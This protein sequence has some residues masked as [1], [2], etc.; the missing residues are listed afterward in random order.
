MK[1]KYNNQKIKTEINGFD[2]LL[3]GGLQL[4][5]LIKEKENDN[6]N[7]VKV[8]SP[9]TIV[10]R[11]ELGTS[12]A[13]LAMQL[14]HGI[15]KSLRGLEQSEQDGAIEIDD[16]VFYTDDKQKINVEDML[17]DTVISKCVAKIVEARAKGVKGKWMR[18][19][20]CKT[21]F[22]L[23][24][25]LNIPINLQNLDA[26]VAQEII[27]YNSRSN[28]LHLALPSKAFSRSSS[29]DVLCIPRKYDRL[30]AYCSKEKPPLCLDELSE[31]F[32]NVHIWSAQDREKTNFEDYC[33]KSSKG[34]IPCIVLDKEFD[35]EDKNLYDKAFVVIYIESNHTDIEQYNADLI[36][37]MRSHTDPTT[38]YVNHQLSIRKSTLQ[39][40]AHGWH[41]YKKRDY[42]IEVYPSSHVVLQRR[43]H[44][45]KGVLRAQLDILS[46]TYQHFIDKKTE[47]DSISALTEFV[48]RPDNCREMNLT[49]LYDNFFKGDCPEDILSDILVG[50]DDSMSQVTAIIGPANTYKRYLTLGGTFSA[51]SKG[52]HTLHVLLDKENDIILQ[53]MICPATIFNNP[54]NILKKRC[55]DC[56]HCYQCIHFKEIRMGCISSDEFFYYLIQQLRVSNESE[57]KSRTIKR[58]VIDDLQKIEF[59]FP[60]IRKDSLFL[61]GLI[62]I[63]RDYNVDLFILCDKSSE[64]VQALRAQADNVICTERTSSYDLDIYIERYSGPS[65]PSHIWGCHVSNI[66]ELFYCDVE[67]NNKKYRIN[68]K[69]IKNFSVYSMEDYWKK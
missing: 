19:Q 4:Q 5:N 47:F 30:G 46:E 31:E 41:L 55:T 58:I 13:L 10:I 49:T 57:D 60:M 12:R 62:S 15:T 32:F 35:K 37:E 69:S 63:C 45:P 20:F 61:T 26:Y 27:E 22:N 43:R 59:C 2:E 39:D 68:E 6:K 44:M 28:A 64:M 38:D 53:K 65:S 14:L 42:G 36:I 34:H 29:N 51:N 66:K 11:G 16:P 18:D 3:F 40:T 21:I 7:K 33:I 67:K 24:Q 9:L 54:K 56:I 8:E 23:P 25:N 17:L 52:A 1:I 50:K 48:G